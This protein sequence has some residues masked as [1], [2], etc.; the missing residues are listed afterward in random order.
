M[1][2]SKILGFGLCV[3]AMLPACGAE[4]ALDAELAPRVPGVAGPL[5]EAPTPRPPVLLVHGI[6]GSSADFAALQQRMIAGGW[7]ADRLSA[8]DFADPSWGCNVDN[9]AQIDS[10]IDAILVETG[11]PAIQ[12]VAHSMG[13]LSSRHFLKNLA[14]TAKATTVVTLG[15]MNHGLASPCSPDFP[16]KPCVWTELC[17][18]GTFVADLNAA[19]AAPAGVR[20]ASIYGTADTT[21]PNTSSPIDGAENIVVAGIDHMGLLDDPGVFEHVRRIL[22]DPPM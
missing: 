18:T 16:G 11:A 3:V 4:P 10:R 14:G 6:N 22:A 17:E 13:S 15:G 19:P 2:A 7:A 8:I 1:R 12:I 20:M 5:P 21:V 9:A